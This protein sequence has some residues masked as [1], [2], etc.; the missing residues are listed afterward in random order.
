MSFENVTPETK[1]YLSKYYNEPDGWRNEIISWATKIIP[2]T[3]K[4][5]DGDV[6]VSKTSIRNIISHGKG[7]LKIFTIPRLSELLQNSVLYHTETREDKQGRIETFYNYAHPLS[8][9]KKPYVI[10]ISVKEDYNGQR[11]YDDEFIQEM[12]DGLADAT[13]PSTRGNLTH[14]TTLSILQNILS[15]KGNSEK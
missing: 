12:A 7:P 13:S 4:S 3:I 6:H 5:P 11:L 15:V 1:E 8:F 14:P 2:E 10:S 9:E